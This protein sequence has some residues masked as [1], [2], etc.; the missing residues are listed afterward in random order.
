MFILILCPLLMTVHLLLSY[1]TRR[2]QKAARSRGEEFSVP[3]VIAL[4]MAAVI[5]FSAPIVPF[6]LVW[7]Q[8]HSTGLSLA[9]L[10]LSNIR[11]LPD[12][13]IAAI[14]GACQVLC[15]TLYRR[16]AKAAAG[17]YTLVEGLVSCSFSPFVEEIIFRGYGR[18]YCNAHSI[19]DPI[20][21]LF[22]AVLFAVAHFHVASAL[23]A[24][25][26]R[27]AATNVIA[28]TAAGIMLYYSYVATGSL[29]TPIMAHFAINAAFF[30]SGRKGV[31]GVPG[32]GY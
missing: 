8:I 13:A 20:A 28:D 23:D 1:P 12:A 29:I 17:K 5:A 16:I 7:R 18:M 30:Y 10:V 15:L 32:T 2:L 3:L 14:V 4:L 11:P 31:P 21:A 9:A 6:V 24:P 27:R 25:S 22:T 26:L 19:S